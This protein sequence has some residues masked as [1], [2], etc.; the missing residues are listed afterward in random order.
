M[1]DG[2]PESVGP[3]MAPDGLVAVLVV[4][5]VVVDYHA[6]AVLHAYESGAVACVGMYDGDTGRLMAVLG[7]LR[8]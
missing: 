3:G 8:P 5:G 7:A 4:D 6:G 2:L 1:V